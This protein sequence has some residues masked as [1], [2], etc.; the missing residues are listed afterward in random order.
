MSHVRIQVVRPRDCRSRR[1]GLPA[2]FQDLDLNCV[3]CSRRVARLT[4]P[5]IVS[6]SF[7]VDTISAVSQ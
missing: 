4:S 5:S 1:I 7:I 6:T 3:L 2:H